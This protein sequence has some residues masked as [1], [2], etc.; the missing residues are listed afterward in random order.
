[1]VGMSRFILSAMVIH[2]KKRALTLSNQGYNI[3]KT[4][5]FCDY[6]QKWA[7][8][9]KFALHKKKSSYVTIEQ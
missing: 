5:N 4:V 7:R 9:A 3:I 8:S 2:F 1:M 6:N